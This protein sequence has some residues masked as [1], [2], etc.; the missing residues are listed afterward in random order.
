MSESTAP[1]GR[2]FLRRLLTTPLGD[3]LRG[4]VTGALYA[5]HLI[6]AAT[7]PVELKRAI[8]RA[9]G[10]ASWRLAPR[11]ELARRLVVDFEIQLDAG[12]DVDDL[13]DT[14]T[15]QLRR[16]PLWRRHLRPDEAPAVTLPPELQRLV[17]KVVRKTRLSRRERRDVSSELSEHFRDGLAAGQSADELAQSFGDVGQAARL[18]RR[19]KLRNR[20]WQ[21]HLISYTFRAAQISVVVALV[22]WAYLA[23]RYFGSEPSITRNYLAEMDAAYVDIPADQSA[24][25]LYREALMNLTPAP[26]VSPGQ[27]EL[28]TLRNEYRT[29]A[30]E[31]QRAVALC[32]DAASRPRM[33]FS[34]QDRSNSEWLAHSGYDGDTIERFITPDGPMIE[35]LLPHFQGMRGLCHLLIADA[36]AATVRGDVETVV[37][38]VSAVLAMSRHARDTHAFLVSEL[39][40]LALSN[41]AAEHTGRLLETYP[42]LLDDEQLAQLS[43]WFEKSLDSGTLVVNFDG[44]R[45]MIADTLQRV[46]SDDGDGNGHVTRQG[47]DYFG[48]WTPNDQRGLWKES[49]AAA[50]AISWMTEPVSASRFATRKEV[51]ETVEE[52]YSVAE[53]R[54]RRPRW[55][56]ESVVEHPLVEEMAGV[57]PT[58]SRW[59]PLPHV[60]PSLLG[61]S[62]AVDEAKQNR[63]ATLAV[64]ALYR[65][66]N[67][68]GEWPETLDQLVPE[69]SHRPS[70]R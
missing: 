56:R 46:F 17:N 30:A 3:L 6:E 36:W 52:L 1:D 18:I 53:R 23:V 37:T 32:R 14:I 2:S 22:A 69:C 29:W 20:S 35:T 47:I 68:H 49:S 50:K 43:D 51:A 66:R 45:A 13:H 4:R 38:D 12:R 64:I 27:D 62:T 57:H 8:R 5:R 42:E 10:R 59:F 15:A 63:D 21:R 31:N 16:R 9:V 7:L 58:E 48:G 11:A 25:P 40:S 26:P 24:W 39:V 41:M 67:R 44:E 60:M 34:F 54:S 55:Q 70:G 61:M 28:N 33:G 65:Y 19:A